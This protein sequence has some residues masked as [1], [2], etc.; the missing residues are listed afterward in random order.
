MRFHE[1]IFLAGLAG[2]LDVGFER[3][4]DVEND[5]RV[6]GGEPTE[7]WDYLMLPWGRLKE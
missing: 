3:M 2:Q 4:R 6:W 1:Q 7:G 5:S